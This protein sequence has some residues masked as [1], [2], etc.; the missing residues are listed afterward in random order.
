MKWIIFQKLQ[1]KIDPINYASSV[2]IAY[3]LNQKIASV[4]ID[5][6]FYYFSEKT[7]KL[8]LNKKLNHLLELNKNNPGTHRILTDSKENIKHFNQIKSKSSKQILLINRIKTNIEIAFREFQEETTAL[9]AIYYQIPTLKDLIDKNVF[10][11]YF[12]NATNL[13]GL[14][15]IEDSEKDVMLLDLDDT[16]NGHPLLFLSNSNAEGTVMEIDFLDPKDIN[17]EDKTTF[18]GE[19]SYI[20]PLLR[21]LTSA[22]LIA[23]KKDLKKTTQEFTD[24]IDQW[25]TIC[26]THPNTNL[27][28]DYFRK[29]L[30][31]YLQQSK[32]EILKN[33]FLKNVSSITHQNLESQIII[34]EA[35]IDKI[36]ELYMRSNTISQETYTAL[37]KV[38]TDDYP[39]FEGRWPIVFYKLIDN[40]QNYLT[41]EPQ[42]NDIQSVRKSIS[43]D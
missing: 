9:L 43:I 20:F 38:K 23:T 41:D 35:P 24:K 21:S 19:S 42:N 17:A 25:A 6:N 30:Q 34:G 18:Y 10:Y 26:Y 8:P 39:K 27:G 32:D 33:P 4:G 15:K 40:T 1:S 13:T 3:L 28:L 16:E 22:E 31:P 29:E 2:K 14:A 36:W 5:D 11:F 7:E 12:S 37:M